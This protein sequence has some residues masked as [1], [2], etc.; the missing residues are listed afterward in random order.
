MNTLQFLF[1]GGL[2]PYCLDASDANDDGEV[3]ISDA[4]SILGDIF[5]GTTRPT[6]PGTMIA[7]SDPTAD[8][9]Y[10]EEEITPWPPLL[11]RAAP[12]LVF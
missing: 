8:R 10:C 2:R 7:G 12:A 9:L 6:E 3:N 4:I 5:L 1:S 11:R